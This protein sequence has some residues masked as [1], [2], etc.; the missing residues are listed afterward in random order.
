MKTF[1]FTSMIA[2]FLFFTYFFAAGCAKKASVAPPP[3][4]VVEIKVDEKKAPV[5]HTPSPVAII[6]V[7][8]IK[9]GAK[10]A[11][12]GFTYEEISAFRFFF[13]RE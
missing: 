1:S 11:G 3:P 2:C 10:A 12:S 9:H 7:E 6:Q 8:D 13:L 5:A 4:P